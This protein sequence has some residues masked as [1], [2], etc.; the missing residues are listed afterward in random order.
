M[1][2]QGWSL[3][4]I[5]EFH[6]HADKWD[7]L[8]QKSYQTPLLESNFV[9]PLLRY[10]GSGSEKL[11]TYYTDS[12]I[13]AMAVFTKV[14]AGCWSTFQPSQAPIGCWLQVPEI[15]TELLAK[16]LR[17]KLMFFPLVFSITQQDPDLLTRPPPN[18]QTNTL[19]YIETSR[20]SVKGSFEEYW[21]TCGK[22]LRKNLRKQRNRLKREKILTRLIMLTSA[23]EMV[24]AVEAYSGLECH[25]W[26]HNTAVSKTNIQG[27]FYTD[28]LSRFA[29][30]N[31][32]LVFQYWH[33]ERLV[34]TDLCILG[35]DSIVILKTTYDENITQ[36]SPALLMKQDA[37]EYIFKNQ[38]V[39]R[40]EFYGKVMEWHTKVSH[41][42][43]K[44][45]HINTYSSF[46]ARIKLIKQ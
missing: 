22:N 16:Q 11:A 33:N 4:P 7:N 40:I 27:Q 5:A 20:I 10:F 37:F 19:D 45:Y 14:K 29:Q 31:R 41:E 23:K 35:H 34:A 1:I 3:Y 8:N 18:K 32:A 12:S 43:R 25:G 39:D 9:K 42:I 38:L 36:Y 17:N 21:S 44:M 26:K 15:P 28:M 6:L 30:E 24:S 46:A 2:K 13:K